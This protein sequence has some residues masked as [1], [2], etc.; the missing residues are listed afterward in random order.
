MTKLARPRRDPLSFLP[1]LGPQ[2]VIDCHDQQLAAGAIGPRARKIEKVEAIAAAGHGDA[3]RAG[4]P[5]CH[6]IDELVAK[7]F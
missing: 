2:S 7:G 1:G 5:R 3:D 6:R 4:R